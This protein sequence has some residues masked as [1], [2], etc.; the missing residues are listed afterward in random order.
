[1]SYLLVQLA[2]YNPECRR[3]QQPMPV[4][5]RRSFST[6]TSNSGDRTM[7]RGRVSNKKSR[8]RKTP[9]RSRT[10]YGWRIRA[11]IEEARIRRLRAA[12]VEVQAE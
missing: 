6:V 12:G 7:P 10:R 11:K 4:L 3:P 8:P 1:M 2:G 9:A 5:R